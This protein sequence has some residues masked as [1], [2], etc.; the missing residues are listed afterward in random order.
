VLLVDPL[1]TEAYLLN[2]PPNSDPHVILLD[3]PDTGEKRIPVPSLTLMDPLPSESSQW[4]GVAQGTC[5]S[6]MYDNIISM[7]RN[8]DF[9]IKDNDT[10]TCVAACRHISLVLWKAYLRS[11]ELEYIR[12]NDLSNFGKP[13]DNSHGWFHTWDT[14]WRTEAFHGLL[15]QQLAASTIA[16]GV[17]NSMRV[18]EVE[19]AETVVE[20]FE[21]EEWQALQLAVASLKE[22]LANLISGYTQEAS[23]QESKASNYQARSVGRLTY[24]ATILVPFSVTAALFSMGGD[25]SAGQSLFWVFWV[26]ATPIAAFL[27]IGIL[28]LERKT[29]DKNKGDTPMPG[30]G[31]V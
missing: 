18:F 29:F 17:R 4:A 13:L 21:K 19:A 5:N 16:N 2:S 31:I 11:Q 28:L 20:S 25:F 27:Y 7:Y 26:I 8:T 23:I 15:Y 6:S 1:I 14:S 3:H 9:K 10:R 22:Q 12:F 24:L 30:Q